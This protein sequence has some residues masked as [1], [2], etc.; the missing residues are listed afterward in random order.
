M[1]SVNPL[2]GYDKISRS[3]VEDQKPQPKV[4]SRRASAATIIIISAVLLFTLVIA[5]TVTA[6]MLE[7]HIKDKDP[8][9]QLSQSRPSATLLGT[10]SHVSPLYLL[11]TPPK[12]PTLKPSSASL[13]ECPSPISRISLLCS[14][15][16][17]KAQP[18]L[19]KGKMSDIQTW[20]SAAMTDQDTCNDGLEEMGWTA[21]D[22]VK[23][24]ARSFKES[25]S[26]SLAIAANMQNLAHKFGL[27]MR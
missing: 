3:D 20:I 21:G 5:L 19:T 18:G 24:R 25:V 13:S 17:M 26:N 14:M 12:T 11:S 16:A 27:T 4:A 15:S 6:L 1:A 2:K 10:L 7:K 9:A 8:P 23:S 22:E